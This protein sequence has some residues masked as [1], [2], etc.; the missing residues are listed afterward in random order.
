MV[1]LM[2]LYTAYLTPADYGV[3]GMVNVTAQFIYVFIN[4]GFDVAMYALLLRRPSEERRRKV[5]GATSSR[6]PSTPPSSSAC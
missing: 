2:P 5:I 3:V 1:F 4:L 6:G